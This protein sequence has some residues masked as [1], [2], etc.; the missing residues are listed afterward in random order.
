MLAERYQKNPKIAHPES[1]VGRLKSHVLRH[2]VCLSTSK[3]SSMLG[4]TPYCPTF[5]KIPIQ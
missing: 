5:A 3:G 4:K 1:R 2:F